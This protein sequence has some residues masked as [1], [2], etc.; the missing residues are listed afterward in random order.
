MKICIYGAGAIGG[1]M[2]AELAFAGYDV[3]LVARGPHL[4]N[5][6]D[7]NAKYGDVLPLHEVLETMAA[8][9]PAAARRR[10]VAA[11]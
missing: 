7:I 6:F 3:S 11:S 10:P 9:T 8:L 4:A 1:Y 5:L 2:A